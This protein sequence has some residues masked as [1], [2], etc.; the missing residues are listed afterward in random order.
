MDWLAST[1]AGTVTV[2]AGTRVL[3]DPALDALHAG[4]QQLVNAISM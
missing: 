4:S 2:P 3:L 1:G